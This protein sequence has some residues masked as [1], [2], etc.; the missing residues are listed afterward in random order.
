MKSHIPNNIAMPSFLFENTLRSQGLCLFFLFL[1]SMQC[2]GDTVCSKKFVRTI[3]LSFFSLEIDHK[4]LSVMLARPC[5]G[6]LII[7]VVAITDICL[8]I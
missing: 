8:V 4:T 5:E 6:A 2:D 3:S 1:M 7:V